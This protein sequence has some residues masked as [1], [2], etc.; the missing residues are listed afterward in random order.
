MEFK[1]KVRTIDG[2]IKQGTI[3]VRNESEAVSKLQGQGYFVISVYRE[4]ID[5]KA[6]AMD[7]L[8]TSPEE[9]KKKG[10]KLKRTGVK[11]REIVLF[12][13]QLGVLLDAGVDII[14]SLD[15]VTLQAETNKFY[16]IVNEVKRNVSKGSSLSGAI[17]LYP[18]SFNKFMIS[19]T[20]I[21][22][23]SGNLPEVLTRICIHMKRVGEVRRR[24]LTAF[25]Y[26]LILI[27]VVLTAVLF[28]LFVII[29]RFITIYEGFNIDLPVIT[30]ILV[31]FSVFV[32]KYVLIEIGVIAV[33]IF[34][35]KKFYSVYE[36]RMKIHRYILNVPFIGEL[37]FR[38]TIVRMC[39]SL[40]L[41]LVNGVPI[42]EA[43]GLLKDAL[44]N[45]YLEFLIEK[46]KTRV[47]G[48]ESVSAGFEELKVFPTIV[49][50][51]MTVG[52]ETG[53]LAQMLNKISRYFDEKVL[54]SINILSA[55]IEPILI[56]IMGLIVGMLV[57]AMFLPVLRISQAGVGM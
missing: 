7:E 46:V 38:T 4:G 22:E 40:N 12:F 6:I 31:N 14:K 18:G 23:E 8:L 37:I 10:L 42:I 41:L 51:M 3:D 53:R 27:G 20:A 45:L 36:N 32:R 43:I 56:V 35:G 2:E 1:Y 26:P 11:T 55:L 17:A 50:R 16:L 52:E 39:D 13:E 28:F 29:P 9:R 33:L 5:E 49:T 47:K 24:L 44:G 21:G 57:V 30:D 19:L 54:Y 34:I 48:G 15:I 25:T